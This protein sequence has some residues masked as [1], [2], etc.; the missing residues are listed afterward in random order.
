MKDK[1]L[2]DFLSFNTACGLRNLAVEIKEKTMIHSNNNTTYYINPAHLTFVENSGYGANL[3]Q[4]S[5]S[6]SCYIRVYVPGVIGYD[7]D[8]NYR[9]W[10]ITA[11]NNKFPDNDLFYIYVRLERNGAS[12]LI[13]YSKTLYNVDGSTPDGSVATSDTY[14]YIRITT[15]Y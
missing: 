5:A 11:Y 15:I 12:A 14:Y 13:A 7:G 4:V 3:I 2:A 1:K 6:S 10:K 9:R 8:G